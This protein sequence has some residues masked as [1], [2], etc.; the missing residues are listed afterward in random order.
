[1]RYFY[2]GL[3]LFSFL[4][5][6]AQQ[7]EWPSGTNKTAAGAITFEN[8]GSNVNTTYSELLPLIAPDSKKLFFIRCGH[9]GNT[10]IG[11]T[12]DIWYSKIEADG[13]WSPAR[14]LG[15]PFNKAFYNS[16][17]GFSPDGNIRF[18]KG[19][20]EHGER[21]K[22]GI[23]QCR[24]TNEGWSE[25]EGIDVKRFNKMYQGKHLHYY[26]HPDNKTL[27]ISFSEKEGDETS[28]IYVCFRAGRNEFTQPMAITQL[29]TPGDD[30]GPFLAAD[31]VT[32]YWSSDRPGGLGSNDIWMSKRLD[33]TWQKWSDPVNL[34]PSIN[35]DDWDSYYSIPASGEYAYMT[36]S[37]NSIGKSDIVRIRLKEEFKPNPVVLIKGKALD[38][39]TNQPVLANI[40][41]ITLAD[42]KEVGVTQSHPQTGEYQ[43]ILPYGKLYGFQATAKG[44]Y[45]VSENL[46]VTDLK[47]YKE[48]SRDLYLVPVEVGQVVRLNNIFFEFGKAVLK[49]ESFIELDNVVKFMNENLTME[50]ALGGH[51][52]NIGSDGANLKL[53]AERAKSVYDYIVGKGVGSTRLSTQG[54]GK[55]RPVADNATDEGK[56]LNRRVEFTITKK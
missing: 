47:Q 34:G 46:D 55:T 20:Y 5:A 31:G 39:K 3:F 12:Q 8:L 22:L 18:I 37:K 19:Y 33:D 21:T 26:M 38:K 41:Y 28:D 44:Y 42:N 17:A 50:I 53:S 43:I 13:T 2:T 10:E 11:E 25:P 56:A 7:V 27:L 52:D 45:S 24:L 36:S 16:V 29:N 15:R 14:H 6:N 35:T 1:M 32:L 30:N 48:I 49:P 51:T 23:S 4:I 40:N 9:P 54:Y